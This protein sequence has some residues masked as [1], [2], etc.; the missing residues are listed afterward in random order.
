M[1]AILPFKRPNHRNL[2]FIETVCKKINDLAIW[3]F[4]NFEI[5]EYLD[6]FGEICAKDALFNKN[7][8]LNFVILSNF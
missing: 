6:C 3:P 7:Q 1:V 5:I 4:L 2:A 8:I